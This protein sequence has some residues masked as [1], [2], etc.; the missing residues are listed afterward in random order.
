M[1]DLIKSLKKDIPKIREN[2]M[3]AITRSDIPGWKKK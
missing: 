3:G 2:V 1:K